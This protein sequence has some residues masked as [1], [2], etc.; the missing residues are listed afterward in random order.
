M[1]TLLGLYMETYEATTWQ[2]G[3][4]IRKALPKFHYSFH[5]VIFQNNTTPRITHFCHNIQIRC[6]WN[7]VFIWF[8]KNYQCSIT[9]GATAN[10]HK[11]VHH[12]KYKSASKINQMRAIPDS[13]LLKL[14]WRCIHGLKLMGIVHTNRCGWMNPVQAAEAST[15]QPSTQSHS[16]VMCTIPNWSEWSQ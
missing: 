15:R 13:N 8:V 4:H 5:T 14:S 2:L 3:K 16:G 7:C 12:H 9:C 1:C 11:V 6:N 10:T